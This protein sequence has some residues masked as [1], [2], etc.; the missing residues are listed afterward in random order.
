MNPRRAVLFCAVALLWA[1]A[2]APVSLPALVAITMATHTLH[3]LHQRLR[4]TYA[5]LLRHAKAVVIAPRGNEGDA[6]LLVQ[7]GGRWSEPAFFDATALPSRAPSVLLIMSERGLDQIL[8]QR[9][10][11][12]DGPAALSLAPLTGKTSAEMLLWPGKTLDASG[13]HQNDARNQ[14]WYGRPRSAPEIV[15]GSPADPRTSALREALSVG[16]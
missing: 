2:A 7:D 9:G 1:A 16:R 8:H 12:L 5:P 6:M 10:L 4:L 11:T 14:A 3:S 13:F 15:G